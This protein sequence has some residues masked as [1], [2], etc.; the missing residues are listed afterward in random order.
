MEMAPWTRKS[1]LISHCNLFFSA[2]YSSALNN[3]SFI[4]IITVHLQLPARH[5]SST[6]E[7]WCFVLS[8]KDLKRQH[9]WAGHTA[10]MKHTHDAGQMKHPQESWRGRCMGKATMRLR[11]YLVTRQGGK[12]ARD[13]HRVPAARDQHTSS[14]HVKEAGRPGLCMPLHEG[15]V[16]MERKS[17]KSH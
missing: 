11:R 2:W 5:F 1:S 13:E 4:R 6:E 10:R 9:H 17:V 3:V 15:A 16:E 12:A 8:N 7:A 14:W